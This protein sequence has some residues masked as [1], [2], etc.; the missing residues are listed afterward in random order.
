[1]NHNHYLNRCKAK[2]VAEPFW[3]S[4]FDFD[5]NFRRKHSPIMQNRRQG[6][7]DLQGTTMT[8]INR[9]VKIFIAGN[10]FVAEGLDCADTQPKSQCT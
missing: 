5:S 2:N 1:M 4:I 6:F 3:I 7:L 8:F 10:T 9:I